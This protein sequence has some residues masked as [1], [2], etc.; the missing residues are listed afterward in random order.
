M[1]NVIDR[2]RSQLDRL[3]DEW[4]HSAYILIYGIGVLVIGWLVS[5]LPFWG[6]LRLVLSL[7][8]Y[9][10]LVVV[11]IRQ[12]REQKITDTDEPTLPTYAPPMPDRP[13]FSA[14][15]TQLPIVRADDTPEAQQQRAMEAILEIRQILRQDRLDKQRA[16]AEAEANALRDEET[17]HQLV[18]DDE[19]HWRDHPSIKRFYRRSLWRVLLAWIICGLIVYVSSLVVNTTY[20]GR[21]AIP[22][23]VAGLFGVWYTIRR[24]G[25]WRWY[26]I[27]I[28][29]SWLFLQFPANGFFGLNGQR[30]RISLLDC[31]NN[32]ISKTR[33]ERYTR[34]PSATVRINTR[35]PDVADKEGNQL[36]EGDPFFELRDVR[37]PNEF[38]EIVSARYMALTLREP[39]VIRRMNED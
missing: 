7:L 29:G 30:L 37:R 32:S 17:V 26:S 27:E 22:G 9:G 3:P 34:W 20:D 5:L 14:T 15:T 12:R 24:Y 39:G 6:W 31:N 23:I 25:D 38:V 13:P 19:I 4:R 10:V 21:W 36:P 35:L 1:M 33:F 11:V 28:I 18:T 8:L 2:M 16:D